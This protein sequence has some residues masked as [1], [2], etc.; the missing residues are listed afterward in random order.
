MR[1]ANVSNTRNVNNINTSGASNNNNASNAYALLPDN[2]STNIIARS[3]S[4]T[5]APKPHSQCDALGDDDL[6]DAS[7]RRISAVMKSSSGKTAL[8]STRLIS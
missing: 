6:S 8:L 1:S 2:A 7:H 4:G 3:K 5:S